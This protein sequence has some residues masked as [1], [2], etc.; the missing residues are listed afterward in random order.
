MKSAT[1]TASAAKT[2]STRQYK[3]P[4]VH[5]VILDIRFHDSLDEASVRKLRGELEP[6]FKF[7]EQQTV[8]EVLMS[9]GPTGQ[10]LERRPKR[11]GGWLFRDENERWVLQTSDSQLVLH[12][13]RPGAWPKGTYVGW[14]S[15]YERFAALHA[16]LGDTYSTLRP[17]R[18]GLRYL[19]RVAI[20]NADAMEKWFTFS[21]RAPA[22]LA[23]PHSFAYRQTW[24]QAGDYDDVSAT[25]GLTKIEIEEAEL[26]VGHQG[27][28]LDIDVFN[29]RVAK[30]PV[31]GALLDWFTRA[32][33]V[34]NKIFEACITDVARKG[35][36]SQ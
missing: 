19:N 33:E 36:D 20:P 5:E 29:L 8:Q 21:L 35:F 32:H 1:A 26:A 24:A 34:E 22:F 31:Y 18:V 12:A 3:S 14:P 17:K 6:S 9:V 11:F 7:A 16:T 10:E 27:V 13:V 2:E 4:P 30:A 23:Q 28:L 15:I 25:V